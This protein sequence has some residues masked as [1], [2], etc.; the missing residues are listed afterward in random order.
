MGGYLYH[1][2]ICSKSEDCQIKLTFH[3]DRN[4]TK[5]QLVYQNWQAKLALLGSKYL[6]AS[7]STISAS[8]N[9]ITRVAAWLF[10]YAAPR[11]L[12]A[13][14]LVLYLLEHVPLEVNIST[15]I[16]RLIWKRSI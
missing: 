12:D 4:A 5:K 7:D 9:T 3:T 6:D 15:G 1:G 10:Q 8:R 2:I 11:A 14:P 13:F 16:P